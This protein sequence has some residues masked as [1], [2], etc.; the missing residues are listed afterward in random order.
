MTSQ[1]LDNFKSKVDSDVVNKTAKGSV[2]RA[3]LAALFKQLAAYIFQLV[4]KS[5]TITINGEVKSL[6]SDV[7]FTIAGDGE[8]VPVPGA[9]GDDAYEVAVRNGF[10]GTEAAWLLSLKGPKGDK[11]DKGDTGTQGL[12]GVQGPKGDTGAQ[13]AQGLQGVQGPKGDTGEQGTQGL[14]GDTGAQGPQGLKGDKGDQGDPGVAIDDTQALA[15]K[16]WSSNKISAEND[17]KLDKNSDKA[18]QSEA[19]SGVDNSKYMTPLATAQA[20]AKVTSTPT[21]Q[22]ETTEYISRITSAGGALD[23][24]TINAVDR[25]YLRGKIDGWL[26][27]LKWAWCPLGSNLN[28][29]LVN[30]VAT[31]GVP[32]SLTNNN[33]TESDYSQPLGFGSG[34]VANT[35]K[36]L[37]SGIIPSSLGLTQRNLSM[38]V[39]V[40]D[41]SE[42]NGTYYMGLTPAS[43]TTPI[44]CASFPLNIGQP[45]YEN[46]G[47]SP[48]INIIS[49]NNSTTWHSN[50]NGVSSRNSTAATLGTTALDT[51]LNLFRVRNNGTFSFAKGRLGFFF[52]GDPLTAA[53][54]KSLNHAIYD[55]NVGA[56]RINV[57]GGLT[58]FLGDSIT[59]GQGATSSSNGRWTTQLCRFLGS[60]EQNVGVASSQLRQ[61]ITTGGATNGIIGG[62]Q[63]HTEMLTIPANSIVIM[64]G[65]NDMGSADST[66][67][68][69]ATIIADFKSK[70]S[71]MISNFMNQRLRVLV[72]SPPWTGNVSATKNL[73]YVAAVAEVCALRGATFIDAY[74][75]FLDTGTPSSYFGDNLHPND[76]GH[77]LLA[78]A[79]YAAFQNRVSRFPTLDFPS[80]NAYSSSSLTVT[81]FGARTGQV[82]SLGHPSLESGIILSAFVS[83]NDTVTVRAT[84][85]TG[86]A[87]DPAS[88]QL[89]VTV[90]I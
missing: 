35:T 30:L 34:T 85:I 84:N 13:G 78:N 29:S 89:K 7:S 18:S 14:K 82:V 68:G 47:Y 5:R 51:E 79:V 44:Y 81:V 53:Q 71:V 76:S 54:S 66:T 63:R 21:L 39:F 49:F 37:A 3:G 64:Y 56:G 60:R 87:I 42:K 16:T 28:A 75:L 52:L 17:K 4:P 50:I 11:G 77:T 43:G 48:S 38:G 32:I 61:T 15:N 72:A 25:F 58:L 6:E 23:A 40:P 24:A 8:T 2:T 31:S 88:I 10:V 55:L 65:T 19:E 33:F 46:R 67:D 22:Q 41:D 86:S 70:L 20:I 80:I 73:A 9:D 57:N 26:P 90:I 69:D 27:L 36:Y 45:S 1:E 62:Y 74:H 83:A 12:Q 59:L